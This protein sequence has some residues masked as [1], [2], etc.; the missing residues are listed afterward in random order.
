MQH[1]PMIETSRRTVE[2]PVQRVGR[3]PSNSHTDLLAREEPLEI[4]L[5]YREQLARTERPIAITM[6]TPGP[7]GHSEMPADASRPSKLSEDAE[8]ALGFLL[9]EG[10]LREPEQVRTVREQ[11]EANKVIVELDDDVFIDL[12]RLGRHFYTTSSCGVCGKS[13]LEALE[14]PL[15][16][17]SAPQDN[18]KIAA[19]LLPQLP[20]I[21]RARQPVFDRTGG[22]HAAAL[23]SAT[24]EL[25]A[26]RED[27]GRHNAVD[28]V[29][30]SRFYAGQTPVQDALLFV[31]GRASFELV[32]KAVAAGIPML[33]AVGAPSSLAVEL[34]SRFEMTLIGFVRDGRFNIYVGERRVGVT[35]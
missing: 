20:D 19:D 35:L 33:A 3:A 26:V 10:L 2:V 21:L 17:L 4:R 28:K 13:S 25:V 6:R 32:Q 30:G 7:S 31:S 14:R 22:L 12:N 27:V 8:L 5:S 11:P 34:A 15:L 16:T 9:G 29:I 1:A 23:F 18:F 24:G